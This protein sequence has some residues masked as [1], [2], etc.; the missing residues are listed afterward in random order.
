MLTNTYIHIPG[1]GPGTEKKIWKCGITSWEDFLKNHNL[2]RCSR[3]RQRLLFSGIEESI[4]QLKS[5]NHIFFAKRIPPGFQWRAF[6]Q[7]REKTAYVD[8]ETTGLSCEYDRITMI[9]IYNGKETK[10][11]VR[12]IDLEEAPAEL[13]KYK[14]LITFNGARFDLPF[15]EHEFPG[16]FN[17]L[18][19]DLM[20]P[21]KKLGYAGGL[22]KIECQLGL[23]RSEETEG[24]SGLDAVRLWNKY[25]RGDDE[26]LE[27]LI[28]YNR[29]D[30][31]NLEKLIEMTYPRMVENEMTMKDALI[32]T[33]SDS[34]LFKS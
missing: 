30:I 27:I 26:A 24:I 33:T 21:L 31:E 11:Y 20:Y 10:T 28:R 9:G 15:I 13:A 17:H 29:E 16:F 2:I 34:A 12:G 8:I 32:V 5:G 18:H 6:R 19:I 25:K 7:F 23:K 14:Q 22:K 4:E 3:N 1:V